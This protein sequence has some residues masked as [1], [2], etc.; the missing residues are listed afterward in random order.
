MRIMADIGQVALIASL[1]GIFALF[2]FLFST[3]SLYM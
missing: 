3:I 2:N 1:A